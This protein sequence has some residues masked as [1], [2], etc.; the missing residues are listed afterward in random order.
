[1]TLSESEA[2]SVVRS[3]MTYAAKKRSVKDQNGTVEARQPPNPSSRPNHAV[4]MICSLHI[5]TYTVLYARRSNRD[6][7]LPS[8]AVE[9]GRTHL[10]RG[11]VL[12]LVE[13]VQEE[14]LDPFCAPPSHG[15]SP[16]VTAEGGQLTAERDHLE[17][18]HEP[19]RGF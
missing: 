17:L 14:I 18:E 2:W 11:K 15:A 19:G 8:T 1:M 5:K 9:P 13:L 4:R 16:Q 7:Y 6:T 12:P 10:F 3:Q